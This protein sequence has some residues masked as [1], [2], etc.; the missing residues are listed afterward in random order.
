MLGCFCNQRY[1]CVNNNLNKITFG[2]GTKVV[3]LSSKCNINIAISNTSYCIF[4][5]SKPIHIWY[6]ISR[7]HTVQHC[8]Q[9]MY[10]SMSNLTIHVDLQPLTNMH[11]TQINIIMFLIVIPWS[12]K[13]Y[14]KSIHEVWQNRS[15]VILTNTNAKSL[16]TLQIL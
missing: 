3:V 12:H 14:M 4:V 13:V 8:K 16:W 1:H 5:L 15:K 10:I 7:L 2:S 6:Y 9:Q 11:Q